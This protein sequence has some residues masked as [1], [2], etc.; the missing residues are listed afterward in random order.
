MSN[1]TL[2]PCPY[3]NRKTS[4]ELVKNEDAFSGMYHVEC[5]Y[6]GARGSV[7]PTEEEAV[8]SWNDG[9]RRRKK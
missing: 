7:E 5:A 9:K 1:E 8:V 6:C 3:C 4:P 2:K